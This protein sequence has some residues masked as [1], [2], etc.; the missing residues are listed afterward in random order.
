MFKITKGA[1]AD[2]EMIG[3]RVLIKEK[4]AAQQTAGGLFLPT[5]SGVPWFGVVVA[6]GGGETAANLAREVIASANKEI[7]L[8]KQ[9]LEIGDQPGFVGAVTAQA[10]NVADASEEI[11]KVERASVGLMVPMKCRVGDVVAY[12]SGIWANSMKV[13]LD[14]Y[15]EFLIIREDYVAMVRHKAGS[16]EAMELAAELGV[17][18]DPA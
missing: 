3:N 4:P 10:R 2:I 7:E 18:F 11:R 13:N 14:G 6:V 17:E 8:S 9:A 1:P 5:G 16:P 12:Q 15:G